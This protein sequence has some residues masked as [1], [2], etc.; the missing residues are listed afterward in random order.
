MEHYDHFYLCRRVITISGIHCQKKAL[1][2][3]AEKNAR[4]N[5]EDTIR[6]D[7]SSKRSVG[8]EKK[9]AVQC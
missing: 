9:K 8:K 1:P 2:D 6:R 4:K 5:D 7:L 3:L